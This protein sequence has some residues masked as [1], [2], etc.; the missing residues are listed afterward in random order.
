MRFGAHIFLWVDRWADAHLGLF[1]RA[2]ALGLQALEIAL[3]DNVAFTPAA[4]R[5]EA[6]RCGM[7]VI[8]SPGALWPMDCDLS[9]DEPA[10]RARG[11]A[12]HGRMVD[13]AAESGAASYTGALYGHP[14][15]V[16]RR[17]PPAEE[18]ARAA[19]G[20]HR[21][22]EHAA[23]AGVRIAIEPMSRFRTH[24]ITT[25]AQALRLVEQAGHPN[26]EVVFDTFH[27]VTEVRDYASAIGALG[28]R[29]WGLHACE[30]DRG[31]P[32]GGLIPWRAVLDAAR[33]ARPDAWVIL[34]TYNT[35]L[36]DFGHSRGVFQDLCPD[37]DAFARRG[38]AFLSAGLADRPADP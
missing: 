9:A 29:L 28:G 35:R 11:L 5:R 19:E 7:D 22:A 31:T 12:W 24:L 32:G 30:N 4:V 3:G 10:D 33:A 26:V 37:G 13:L 6:E 8:V 1:A 23:R 34:E 17:R 16:L 20:L 14:G 25:P 18:L 21:L 36:G 27:M 2:R 15:R 38:L